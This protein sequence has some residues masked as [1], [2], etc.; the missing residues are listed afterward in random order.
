MGISNPLFSHE[1]C[2]QGD[3]TL[4]AANP[5]P[6][7]NDDGTKLRR[8]ADFMRLLAPPP[9]GAASPGAHSGEGVFHAI[10]CAF[11][12]TPAFVTGSSPI[13]ALD[14]VTFRPYSDFLLH[15][16]GSLAD[17]VE[18][19]GATGREMRTAPLWGVGVQPVFLHD[20]R[21]SS[22]A[23]AILAHDGQGRAARDRYAALPGDRQNALLAFLGSL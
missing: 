11:C 7:L 22:L 1:N 18:R 6:G 9:P 3:C 13:K 15:D 21:A 23:Q 14:H 20:G 8:V 17:G 12:H 5:A 2:P 10:G 4:L 16:M 19:G